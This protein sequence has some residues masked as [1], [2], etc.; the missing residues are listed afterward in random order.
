[1]SSFLAAT[2]GLCIRYEVLFSKLHPP[3]MSNFQNVDKIMPTSKQSIIHLQLSFSLF[4]YSTSL[5]N[6][7]ITFSIMVSLLR[8]C[9]LSGDSIFTVPVSSN[10]DK[11]QGWGGWG[12]NFLLP[13]SFSGLPPITRVFNKGRNSP[14]IPH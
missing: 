2:R 14:A 6:C 13:M 3:F 7:V 8:L 5:L 9:N 11:G 4:S 12:E 1:M 10:I